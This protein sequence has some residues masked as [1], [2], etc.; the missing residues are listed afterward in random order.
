MRVPLSLKEGQME[1]RYN[2]I[3]LVA[4]RSERNSEHRVTRRTEGKRPK[5]VSFSGN[6]PIPS[7]P[8]MTYGTLVLTE[9]KWDEW[10]GSVPREDFMGGM[11]T[12]EQAAAT[13]VGSRTGI[14]YGC[15]LCSF[16]SDDL[17]EAEEHVHKHVNKF[18]KQFTFEQDYICPYCERR[19]VQAGSLQNHIESEH[20]SEEEDDGE[21]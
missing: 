5:T 6:Y 19:Y 10:F 7:N 3:Y 17:E 15:P 13:L 11:E 9:E 2:A 21:K 8:D 18:C 14:H 4:Q 20:I 16:T 1:I 12:A